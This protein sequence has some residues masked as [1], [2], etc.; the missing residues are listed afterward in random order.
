MPNR[1]QESEKS[2]FE[3]NGRTPQEPSQS[4]ARRACRWRCAAG[5]VRGLVRWPR[6]AAARASARPA[7]G[8]PRSPFDVADRANRRRQDAR[9]FPAESRVACRSS[10]GVARRWIARA[11]H[12]AAEGADGGRGAQPDHADRGDGLAYPNRD[13]HGGYQRRETRAPARQAARHIT[14][15]ARAGRAV[16]QP[17]GCALPVRRCRDHHP[18]RVAFA[19]GIEARRLA[20]A[21]PRAATQARWRPHGDRPIG[22]RGAAERASRLPR[23]ATRPRYRDRAGRSRRRRRRRAAAGDDPR[24]RRPDTLVG[25]LGALCHARDLRGVAAP[26]AGD[27]V[28]QHAHAGRAGV[29]GAVAHQRR[30]A[31]DRP[32]PRLARR[33]A[34][35]QGGSGDGC[36]NAA[37]RGCHLDARS[38]HR[39]G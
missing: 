28:R 21:R 29:P 2:G 14:D 3:L 32:A 12:L 8:S 6:L 16:A 15:H 27:R 5:A 9:R 36:G 30:L 38:R 19:R 7:G 26:Q 1:A 11:L 22:D 20:G 10:K 4:I 34:T 39:L 18:R 35:A 31:A 37:R 13:A 17:S 23:S 24:T 33:D 25:P